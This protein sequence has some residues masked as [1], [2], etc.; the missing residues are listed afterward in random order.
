LVVMVVLVVQVVLVA[1]L[2]SAN[3]LTRSDS[4]AAD[5]AACVCRLVCMPLWLPL[6]QMFKLDQRGVG[7]NDQQIPDWK[8]LSEQEKMNDYLFVIMVCAGCRV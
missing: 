3:T 2:G 6:S 1:V 5:V 8:D 4:D 7:W